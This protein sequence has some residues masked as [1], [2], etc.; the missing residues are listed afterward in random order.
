MDAEEIAKNFL[1][2]RA[3]ASPSQRISPGVDDNCGTTSGTAIA[4]ARDSF[5]WIFRCARYYVSSK[6]SAML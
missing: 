6:M 4:P 3:D 2:L 5:I 1:V